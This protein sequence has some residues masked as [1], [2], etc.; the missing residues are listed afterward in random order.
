MKGSLKNPAPRSL[1][2]ARYAI[3]VHYFLQNWN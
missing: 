2:L 3:V 1:A